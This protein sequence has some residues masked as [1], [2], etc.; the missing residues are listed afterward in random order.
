MFKVGLYSLVMF[1]VGLYSLVMF[2]VGL[3]TVQPSNVQSGTD[4]FKFIKV[5][6]C[7]DGP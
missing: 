3:L 5:G 7:G 4:F 6:R 2:K 1:K